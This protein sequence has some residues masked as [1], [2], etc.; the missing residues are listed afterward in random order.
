MKTERIM[1]LILW[2]LWA[3]T[4]FILLIGIYMEYKDNAEAVQVYLF[5]IMS[6]GMTAL[7]LLYSISIDISKLTKIKLKVKGGEN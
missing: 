7:L 3:I 1:E 6:I 5:F 2:I 4:W